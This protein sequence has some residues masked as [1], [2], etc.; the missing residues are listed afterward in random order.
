MGGSADLPIT[1]SPLAFCG[2]NIRDK[3]AEEGLG[4]G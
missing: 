4:R 3:A 2:L 1:A